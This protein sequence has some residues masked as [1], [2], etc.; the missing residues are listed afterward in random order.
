M[1][2][3]DS[4]MTLVSI[5]FE[6]ANEKRTSPCAVGIVVSD[7]TQIVDEYYSLINPLTDFRAMNIRIHGITPEHVRYAPTFTDVWPVLSTYLQQGM[8]IAHNASFDMSVLRNTL[9]RF[10]LTYPDLNYLC[11]VMLAKQIWP[12]LHNHKLD[13]LATFHQIPFEHHHA[14]EDARVAAKLF[15]KSLNES[16]QHTIEGLLAMY[17]IQSGKIFHHGYHAPKKK[18]MRQY[19]QIFLT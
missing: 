5:D 1:I 4:N 12:Q 11:T 19:K 14:L 8:V 9:D 18:K 17:H 7:G 10:G 16:K 13:T 6:T 3:V 2:K 15:S